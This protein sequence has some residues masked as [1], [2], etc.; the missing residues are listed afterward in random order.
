MI[1]EFVSAPIAAF[2]LPVVGLTPS[3]NAFLIRVDTDPVAAGVQTSPNFSLGSGTRSFSFS[4]ATSAALG[5]GLGGSIF[6]GTAA[7]PDLDTYVLSYL[8]S[9]DCNKIILPSLRAPS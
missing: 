6:G 9:V 7:T 3:S 4:T 5:L 2:V 8:P 1:R